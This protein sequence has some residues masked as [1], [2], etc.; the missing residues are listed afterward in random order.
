MPLRKVSILSIT[1]SDVTGYSGMQSDVKTISEMGGHTVSVVTAMGTMLAPGKQHFD[2]MPVSLVEEQLRSCMDFNPP[3]AV[4]IGMVRNAD[5]ARTIGERLSSYPAPIVCAPGILTFDGHR[6]ADNDTVTAITT[7]LIPCARLLILRCKEA[8]LVLNRAITSDEDMLESARMFRRMGARWV[9]LRGGLQTQGRCTALLLGPDVCRF[10]ASYNIDGWQQHG[11]GG[12]LAT[13]IATRLAFGD[14][15]P[16]A[17]NKAHDYVRS[18]V[19]YAVTPDARNWRPSDL[20][21]QFLSL[22]AQHY[23]SAHD[24]AFYA[25]KLCISTR[26]LSQL[27]NKYVFKS[28]KQVISDYVAQE[29]RILLDTTRLSVQEIAYRLGF[30][31][32]AS[33]SKFYKQHKGQ[34]P[35]SVRQ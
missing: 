27:T 9:M 11:V 17:V 3:E 7:S 12:T 32:Q 31:D 13:A 18:Q 23:R 20:Y 30:P 5:V 22:V 34:S 25:D 16:T 21:N 29:A 2:D 4:K 14:D 19:V 1:A 8:E 26:Y 35:S 6:L 24:V 10:F 33:F 15:V 28:P